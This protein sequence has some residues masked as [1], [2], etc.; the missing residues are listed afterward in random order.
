TAG[1]DDAASYDARDAVLQALAGLSRRQRAVIVLR[2]YEDL[3]ETEIAAALG[4][5]AGTVKSAASRAMAKLREH[6][7]LAARQEEVA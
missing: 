5:S 2:Y 3:S 6:P 7:G 4:C 1:P